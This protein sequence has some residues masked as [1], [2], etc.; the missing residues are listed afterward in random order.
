M[1]WHNPPESKGCKIYLRRSANLHD[2]GDWPEQHRWLREKL[3]K[4]HRTFSP[5]VKQLD[6][7]TVAPLSTT[8]DA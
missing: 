2:R 5:V 6:V 8:M 4:L 7:S 1:T 3:E